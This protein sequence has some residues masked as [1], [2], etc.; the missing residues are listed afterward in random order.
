MK[1]KYLL[2]ILALIFAIAGTSCTSI[3]QAPV[4]VPPAAPVWTGISDCAKGVWCY[5]G[6]ISSKVTPAMLA[7]NVGAFCPNYSKADKNK[8]WVKFVAAIAY[9]ES[10]WDPKNTYKETTM[11]IDPITGK[12]VESDGMLQL[13]CQD[14]VNYA[15]LPSAANMDC[16]KHPGAMFD[17][18]VN[19]SFG[20]EIMDHLIKRNP[21]LDISSTKSV[22][23]YWSS[24]RIG[25]DASRVKLRKLMP[26]CGA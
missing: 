4:P 24:A 26:E 18:I 25:H 5:D 10:A 13:S 7:A 6:L 17:P 22:G 23:A 14:V 11:G 20:V 9:A 8:F 15:S 16:R 3:P 12:T 1:I 21:S 19:L 2:P